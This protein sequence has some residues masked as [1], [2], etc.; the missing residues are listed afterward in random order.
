[1][2]RAK[3]LP[4]FLVLIVLVASFFLENPIVYVP[5]IVFGTYISGI[6]FDFSKGGRRPISRGLRD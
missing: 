5:F 4:S 6:I 2:L 3:W 1:M